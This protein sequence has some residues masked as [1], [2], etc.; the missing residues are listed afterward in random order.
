MQTKWLLKA[1][2][3]EKLP[4]AIAARGKQ[5]FGVPVG[6][7]LRHELRGWARERL[8]GNRALAAWFRPAAIEQLLAEHDSGRVN[9]GKRL[10]ALLM[11]AV[12]QNQISKGNS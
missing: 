2:F 11:V 5:G 1:A 6:Q 12:W 10:W 3:G 7:W 8:I 9:H 4:P